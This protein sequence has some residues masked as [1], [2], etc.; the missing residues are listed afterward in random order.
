MKLFFNYLYYETGGQ[1]VGVGGNE[2]N[3][4]YQKNK[5]HLTTCP[6]HIRSDLSERGFK[7]GFKTMQFLLKLSKI[8]P[9]GQKPSMEKFHL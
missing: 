4:V 6:T 9:F 1:K 5:S 7:E 3:R 8:F 2:M